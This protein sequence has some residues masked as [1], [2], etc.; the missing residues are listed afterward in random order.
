MHTD[1][2]A[3]SPPPP[4]YGGEPSKQ[5]RSTE[6]AADA[7]WRRLR[8]RL[9]EEWLDAIRR[10]RTKDDDFEASLDIWTVALTAELKNPAR[11]ETAASMLAR[12][13]KLAEG[14]EEAREAPSDA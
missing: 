9:S 7:V 14:I 1:R 5:A 11:R 4:S 2:M 6:R 12:L 13:R 8:A 3:S 10:L